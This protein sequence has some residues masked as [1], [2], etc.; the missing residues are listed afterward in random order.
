[1]V[2]FLELDFEAKK[3]QK[4]DGRKDNFCDGGVETT[5]AS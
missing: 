2:D 5:G 4:L 1:M 3:K